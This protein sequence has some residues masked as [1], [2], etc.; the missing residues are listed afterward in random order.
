MIAAQLAKC[1]L[2]TTSRSNLVEYRS[3]AWF[4]IDMHYNA[5]S[6]SDVEFHFDWSFHERITAN[7]LSNG[8]R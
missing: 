2:R 5:C 6:H 4:H 8:R 7:P 1:P 3:C